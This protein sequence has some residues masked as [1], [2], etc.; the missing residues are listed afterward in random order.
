M[1]IRSFIFLASPDLSGL[2][3][4]MLE[5]GTLLPIFIIGALHGVGIWMG[6]MQVLILLG[7]ILIAW[8]LTRNRSLTARILSF[9][10]AY[11]VANFATTLALLLWLS[12]R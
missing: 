3:Q 9:V 4:L 12:N 2:G 11:L 1:Q 10:F 5:R 6:A 8:A 7:I